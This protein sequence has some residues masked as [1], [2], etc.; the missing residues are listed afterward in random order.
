[1]DDPSNRRILCFATHGEAHLD[2]QRIRCLLEPLQPTSYPFDYA[3]KLA[4]AAGLL[5]AVMAQRPELVVMEGT[6]VAG[7]VAVLAMDAVLGVPFVFSSG[8]AVGPYLRLRSRPAGLL[9]GVYERLLCRRCAG[10]VGWTPYL[11]GRAI[12]FGASRAMTAPGWAHDSAKDGSRERIRELLSVDAG[13]MMVGLV[14]SLDWRASV[15][16]AYGLELIRAVQQTER[17]D[18]VVCI[19]GDGSGRKRLQELAGAD[20]GSRV[21]LPGRVP[22]GEVADYLAAFD[23]ASLP[24][25]VDRVGAF[26]YSTKLGEYLAAG[27]PIV[28]GQNPLAYDLGEE[29]FFRLPGAAPWSHTYTAA[30]AE[31]LQSLTSEQ[32]VERRAA[33]LKRQDHQFDKLAQQRRMRAFIED[34][35]GEHRIVEQ[36]GS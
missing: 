22:P 36:V 31:L 4:S 23:L 30:L 3:R 18:L 5:R 1:V 28:T 20:L 7:G 21:L 2:G 14:G 8:D 11:V 25:S 34:L 29:D 10:Y 9:G 32:L 19:V 24:Q 15:G 26:R 33:T 35:L 6:G 17:R 27:L 13:A 12:T 16:Y